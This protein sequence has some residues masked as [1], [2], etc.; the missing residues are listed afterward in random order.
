MAHHRVDEHDDDN[1]QINQQNRNLAD[2]D[3]QNADANQNAMP[4]LLNVLM[5]GPR[6]KPN[7]IRAQ[8]LR[9]PTNTL[10]E[11]YYGRNASDLNLTNKKATKRKMELLFKRVEKMFG[12]QLCNEG[13]YPS[14]GDGDAEQWQKNSYLMNINQREAAAALMALWTHKQLIQLNQIHSLILCTDN[15]S[16]LEKIYIQLTTI[17]I[18]G[19]QNIK[20]DTFSRLEWRGDF[21]TIVPSDPADNLLGINRVNA[22]EGQIIKS[23][24]LKL[25]PGDQLAIL[26]A[27]IPLVNNYSDLAAAVGL[28]STTIQ[29]MINNSNWETLRQHRAGLTIMARYLKLNEIYSL[30]L[31]V[32]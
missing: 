19:L 1:Q 17:L 14:T 11:Q 25:P 22:G 8:Q 30:V 29:L 15:Q 7:I 27:S 10:F 9:D 20:A 12:L 18:P 32:G 13:M 4:D 21:Q 5:S 28:V 31:L 26:M 6:D 23:Y 24:Q 16:L 3:A 2:H